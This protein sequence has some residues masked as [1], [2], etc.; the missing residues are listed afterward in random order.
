MNL[1][2]RIHQEINSYKNLKDGWDHDGSQ[3]IL[4]KTIHNAINF[5]N[6][7]G[8]LLELIDEDYIYPTG[9]GT[10]VIDFQN[11]NGDLASVEIRESSIGYFFQ[12]EGHISTVDSYKPIENEYLSPKLKSIIQ[13]IYEPNL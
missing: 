8:N 3:L 10:I 6:S 12:T 4:L 13:K 2:E 1:I 5:V 7:L 11:E 9:D